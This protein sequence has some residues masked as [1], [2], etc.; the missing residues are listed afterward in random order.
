MSTV[1]E[2][3]KAIARHHYENTRNLEAAFELV[4]PDVVFQAVP[5]LP[6]TYEGWKQGHAMFLEAIPDQ[7]L[8]L[9][10]QI[11]EGD[12]VFTRWTFTGTHQGALMGIPPTGRPI[13]I[14]GISI[15]RI[16]GGKVVEH[17]AQMDMVGLMQQLGVIPAP[18]QA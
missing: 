18:A 14:K 17:V 7:Q 8:T 6:P 11:A 3:N 1:S 16:R 15:D 5:G 10:D 4:S 2:Q 13:A 12:T 9:D